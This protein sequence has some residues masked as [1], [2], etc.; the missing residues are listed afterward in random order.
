LPSHEFNRLVVVIVRHVV[1]TIC[2]RF[3]ELTFDT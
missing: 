2:D 3:F 1:K